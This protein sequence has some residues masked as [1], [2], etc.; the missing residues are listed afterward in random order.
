M[1][2][3]LCLIYAAVCIV[4]FRFL[5]VPLS[6][7][8]VTTAVVG[9]IFIIGFV[10]VVMN[11][12]HPFS[13]DGRIYFYATPVSP[14]VNG[15]VVDVPVRPNSTVKKGEVLFRLDPRPFEYAVSRRKAALAAAEQVVSEQQA[16]LKAAEASVRSAVASRDQ[17][18]GDFERHNNANKNP[19]MSP[20]SMEQI[21]DLR[22][23]YLAAEA[24]LSAAEAQEEQSRLAANNKIDGVDT[25]V[26]QLEAELLRAQF[27]MEQSV[28]RAPTDG[29]ATQIFLHPG[30]MAV[31]LPLK[32][33]MTF[34]H[35]DRK[36]FAA[37]FDQIALQR[38]REGDQA[39]LSFAGVPGRVFAARVQT[40]LK[41]MAEGELEPSGALLTPKAPFGSGRVIAVFEPIDD[42]STFELPGG[43]TA[44]V[45][46]YTDHWSEFALIRKILLRIREW[47]NFLVFER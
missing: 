23:A 38:V 27:E 34:V 47:Q 37:S 40:V 21:D 44:E 36:L 16:A 1:T 24:A 3:L 17:A 46:I 35:T 15:Q 32:P 9:G 8:T 14:A 30:M 10:V 25:N 39:E 29:Y 2:T 42:L 6:K 12:N 5:K 43:A 11:Y 45:A 7:W 19:R 18:K 33:V 4:I 20:F 31:S 28:Y 41:F 13:K 26:A 22:N